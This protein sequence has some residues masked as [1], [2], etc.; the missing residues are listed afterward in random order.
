MSFDGWN[1]GS[2][3]LIGGDHRGVC[4]PATRGRARFWSR[5]L[6]CGGPERTA[7]GT[8]VSALEMGIACRRFYA[9][10]MAGVRSSLHGE[11]QSASSVDRA[12]RPRQRRSRL[13]SPMGCGL[14]DARSSW[15]ASQLLPGHA[16]MVEASALHEFYNLQ[17]SSMPR[18]GGGACIIAPALLARTRM[19][20][21]QSAADQLMVDPWF[22]GPDQQPDCPAC[23]QWWPLRPGPAFR[24]LPEQHP[25]L[26]RQLPQRPP[27]PEPAAGDA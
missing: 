20:R 21:H 9:A 27:A 14:R 24:A 1:K 12:P 18:S 10:S 6:R 7:S 23:S 19:L 16:L 4:A 11:R 25:R 3:S 17:L 22:D 8:V 5:V 15:P 26:H 13:P 2:F